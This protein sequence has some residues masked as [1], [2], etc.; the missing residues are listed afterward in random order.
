MHS[1]SFSTDVLN[2]LSSKP[3]ELPSKWIYNELGDEL[4]LRVTKMPEYY[5]KAAEKEIFEHQSET[6][7]RNLNL[8]SL[9]QNIDIIE[10]GAGDGEKSIILLRNIIER[11]RK[12]HYIPIDISKTSLD[13][14]LSTLKNEIPT[15]PVYQQEGEY[16]NALSVFREASDSWSKHN[17]VVLF[18]G[19]SIGNMDQNDAD[20]FISQ[21]VCFLEKGDKLILGVD[22]I[23]PE[24][25]IL[26]A[27]SGP[28]N[29]NFKLNILKRINT[30]LGGNFNLSTFSNKS[31]YSIEEGVL[32]DFIQSDKHQEVYIR[33]I[34]KTFQLEKGETIQVD[35]S[36]K[37]NDD[38][39]SQ[40]LINEKLKFV[41]KLTDSRSYFADYIYECV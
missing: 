25:V 36:Y 14:L 33:N 1:S 29:L 9:R 15:L 12:F 5:L 37:Y 22:L 24:T 27:Y 10:L 18:L 34:N 26:P 3:K 28:H 11:D 4:F 17:R 13:L 21:L 19:N 40:L 23:K 20:Y 2:G 7:I 16:L 31:T 6:I 30:E 39:V 35:I 32:R 8:S 38:R 41:C